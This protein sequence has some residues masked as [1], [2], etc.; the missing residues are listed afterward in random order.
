MAAAV[1]NQDFSPSS[2]RRVTLR[3]VT[4]TAPALRTIV[5]DGEASSCRAVS[6]VAEA[7]GAAVVAVSKATPD[8]AQVRAVRPDVVVLELALAG[9]RGLGIV[10]ALLGAL[11]QCAIIL[12]SPFD[13][14]RESALD[15][16]A[17][18]LVGKDDL[19]DLG[20]CFRRLAT[21][22]TRGVATLAAEDSPQA[23]V[24][25]AEASVPSPAPGDAGDDSA[26]PDVSTVAVAGRDMPSA[27]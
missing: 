20:L 17:Y 8:L 1:F 10:P 4:G 18:D 5:Y 16:G 3:P 9:A 26:G 7:A 14:L 2:G 12:L 23:A 27:G 21:R 13:T 15:A 24:A 25:E 11:P 6:A 22:G 19:H